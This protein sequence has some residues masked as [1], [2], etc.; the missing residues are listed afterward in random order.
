VYIIKFIAIAGF[1]IT[2]AFIILII[3]G[4]NTEKQKTYIGV[5][6][7]HKETTEKK[8]NKVTITDNQMVVARLIRANSW[9]Q[10]DYMFKYQLKYVCAV[11]Y[12]ISQNTYRICLTDNIIILDKTNF[13]KR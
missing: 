4:F 3:A 13:T 5:C 10:A 11:G 6:L 1:I 12:T 2:G 8:G 7:T 9:Q